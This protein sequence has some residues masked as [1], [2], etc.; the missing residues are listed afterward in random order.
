[1]SRGGVHCPTCAALVVIAAAVFSVWQAVKS[2][3]A[4]RRR[5]K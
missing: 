5:R 4:S 2:W 1:M 3:R